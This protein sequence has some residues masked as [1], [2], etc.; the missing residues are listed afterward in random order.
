MH[1][2]LLRLLT[3]WGLTQCTNIGFFG[4]S[5]GGGGGLL[6]QSSEPED[7]GERFLQNF[8]PIYQAKRYLN[9]RRP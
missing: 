2:R 1:K 4:R 3:F 6:H 9:L 8:S 7:V 5:E